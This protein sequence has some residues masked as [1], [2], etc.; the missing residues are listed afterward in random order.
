MYLLA[1]VFVSATSKD[2]ESDV[3]ES[4]GDKGDID[5]LVQ[6]E[7]GVGKSSFQ[8]DFDFQYLTIATELAQ[9][10]GETLSAGIV[11]HRSNLQVE[12]DARDENE[13]RNQ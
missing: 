10:R 12:G 11:R 2:N 7:V 9:M 6:D 4:E 1:I 3:E 13:L 8:I 5:G